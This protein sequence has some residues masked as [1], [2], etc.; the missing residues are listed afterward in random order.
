MDSVESLIKKEGRN[1]CL[2]G[3][4]LMLAGAGMLMFFLIGEGGMG[5]ILIYGIPAL[6]VGLYFFQA[7]WK[8]LTKIGGSAELKR[9]GERAAFPE[10]PR[11]MYLGTGEG[12][13]GRF[14]DMEGNA[15]GDI[16]EKKTTMS[17]TAG[18]LSLSSASASLPLPRVYQ[19][20]EDGEVLY[21]VE[22][23]G[24]SLRPKA[25]VKGS[26][27]TYVGLMKAK[28]DK[29]S[30]QMVF[31][32]QKKDETLYYTS[33]DPYIGKYYIKDSRDRTLLTLKN[34][35]IPV[36]APDKLQRMHGSVIEWE[37]TE[38]I[39]YTLLL[40]IFFLSHTEQ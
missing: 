17:R 28:K 22:R 14:Y 4:A 16:T 37:T 2:S 24:F 18:L 5:L 6:G 27:D 30:K 40:F 3:I 29:E 39:P 9:T 12:R 1:Q 7:G 15:M 34:G 38:N 21:E 33:G 26:E 10:V 35:A 19:V 11:T 23:K 32:Y 25:Y 20:R 31:S 13:D 8:D 36:G